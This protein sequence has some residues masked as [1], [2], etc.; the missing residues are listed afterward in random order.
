MASFPLNGEFLEKLG[1]GGGRSPE[2]RSSSE[3]LTQLTDMHNI[4]TTMINADFQSLANI[5]SIID[6]LNQTVQVEQDGVNEMLV[7]ADFLK[8]VLCNF[9][10]PYVKKTGNSAVDFMGDS[11]MTFCLSNGPFL[12]ACLFT[13]NQM[14]T[15][16][17]TENPVEVLNTSVIVLG[18]I[19]ELQNKSVVWET[20][21]DLPYLFLPGSLDEK[22]Q[23]GIKLLENIN[24]ILQIVQKGYPQANTPLK[25]VTPTI[26]EAIHF[27]QYILHWPGRGVN[28]SLQDVLSGQ[29]RVSTSQEQALLDTVVIPLDKALLLVDFNAFSSYICV[30]LNG[31][32]APTKD[33]LN[34]L[35]ANNGLQPVFERIDRNK[36][37]EQALL[38]VDF[39]AF[40]SYICVGL[41]GSGTPTKD[42]LNSLCANNG[43]QPVFERID[44]N[45]VAEQIFLAWSRG[46]SRSDVHFAILRVSNL[47]SLFVP[48][49]EDI[50]STLATAGTV[51]NDWLLAVTDS[52]LLSMNKTTREITFVDMTTAVLHTLREIPGWPSMQRALGVGVG[53]MEFATDLL[54]TQTGGAARTPLC[55]P[56]PGSDPSTSSSRKNRGSEQL[57]SEM[58]AS[59]EQRAGDRDTDET[60]SSCSSSSEGGTDPGDTGD[61]RGGSRR[62]KGGAE[63]VRRA[64]PLVEFIQLIDET[65]GYASTKLV[66]CEDREEEQKQ[67]ERERAPAL[68]IR[69]VV[70]D[71]KPYRCSACEKTFKRAWELLSHEVV[72]NS[73]RPF[74]CHACPARFKRHSDYKSHRMVH[75]ELRPFGCESCGKTFK[76]SSN[77]QEHRRSHSG[78]RPHPCPRCA[79]SFKTPY[80]LQRH[81]LVHATDKP[82]QCEDCGKGFPTAATLLAHR[83]QHCDDKPHACPVCGKRFAYGH[84]LKVLQ[85]GQQVACSSLTALWAD[86]FTQ[87]TLVQED[88]P[89]LLCNQNPSLLL[90]RLQKTVDPLITKIR[91]HDDRSAPYPERAP[92]LALRAEGARGGSGDNGVR[93]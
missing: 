64:A 37:A 73:E 80:E 3:L 65:G 33:S 87:V 70:I 32:G 36:V 8:K 92:R 31:S 10:L 93:H 28:I 29:P 18:V 74:R 76:R 71:D 17:M 53:I 27:L 44:R 56:N 20:L 47:L 78:A 79:K 89:A 67:E 46:V 19:A 58:R 30:G 91:G 86:L 59:G 22:V 41:N 24:S 69:E 60:E 66:P 39:N 25:S 7:S 42:S 35:C 55:T 68:E 88:W 82:C 51:L 54:K 50:T 40:S 9:T 84:S 77:L 75:T 45:K 26:D 83:R 16:V 23:L 38:L 61:K 34:S 85:P 62:R 15:R 90:M 6:T 5:T 1:I 4:W 43:L 11:Y 72:H 21:L 49:S 48:G 81:G 13:M 12:E 2:Q 14:F 52:I 63:P 57:L